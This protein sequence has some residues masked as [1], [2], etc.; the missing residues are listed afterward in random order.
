M[1]EKAIEEKI[2]L[3]IHK[4]KNWDEVKQTDSDAWVLEE[5][6]DW[7]KELKT[8]ISKT[9]DRNIIFQAEHDFLDAM[10]ER[11]G[12]KVSGAMLGKLWS[13]CR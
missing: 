6:L 4:V 9:K 10:T 13:I 5:D 12:S 1:S 11:Y 7:M 2:P 3:K 8:N